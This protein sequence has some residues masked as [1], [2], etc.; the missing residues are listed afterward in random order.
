MNASSNAFRP[1]LTAMEDRLA[2]SGVTYDPQARTIDVTGSNS[3]DV[4]TVS[5]IDTNSNG[6]A[7]ANDLLTV[8]MTTPSAGLTYRPVTLPLGAVSR[9]T[10]NLLDG[11]DRFN[12]DPRVSVPLSVSGGNGNDVIYGGAAGDILVGGYGSDT[13]YGRGGDD[14]LFGD[15]LLGPVNP[16]LEGTDF[17]DGG[18]GTNRMHFGGGFDHYLNGTNTGT[19]IWLDYPESEIPT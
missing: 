11:D 3:A 7:D 19:N 12:T 17:L 9:I 18:S 6:L 2:L 16:A 15:Q 10:A 5:V 1:T 14:Y 8:A 13:I 4:V